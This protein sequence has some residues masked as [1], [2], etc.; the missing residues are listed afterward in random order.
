[1]VIVQL[2]LTAV[3]AVSKNEKPIFKEYSYSLY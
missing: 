3:A 2:P 1:M